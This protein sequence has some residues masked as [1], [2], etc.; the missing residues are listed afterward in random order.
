MGLWRPIPQRNLIPIP[1]QGQ[2]LQRHFLADSADGSS[3]ADYEIL[4]DPAFL[5]DV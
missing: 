4:D 1:W 3:R 2:W 5:W